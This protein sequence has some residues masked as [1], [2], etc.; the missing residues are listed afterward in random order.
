MQ[1]SD[2]IPQS[3]ITLVL[4]GY[5]GEYGW[6][7]FGDFK[8]F[9]PDYYSYHKG[10][11]ETWDNPNKS[12]VILN[13]HGRKVSIEAQEKWLEESNAISRRVAEEERR[14]AE[15]EEQKRLERVAKYE[16]EASRRAHGAS[17]V[18]QQIEC[19]ERKRV[20]A[21]VDEANE[22]V[23]SASKLAAILKNL[24]ADR[25]QSVDLESF[26]FNAERIRRFLPV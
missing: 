17:V 2:K 3:D 18:A 6:P 24:P 5:K 15:R 22:L 25:V 12:S 7:T 14:N 8:Q 16:Q 21:Q 1:E 10:G 19:S 23:L 20:D 11:W 13:W 26:I 4:P 9:L